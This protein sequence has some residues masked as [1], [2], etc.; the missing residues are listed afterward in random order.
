MLLPP[1]KFEEADANDVIKLSDIQH[2]AHARI[3][4]V[5]NP[6]KGDEVEVYAKDKLIAL[7]PLSPTGETIVQVSRRV[8]LDFAGTGPTPFKYIVYSGS[9]G[10]PSPSVE[11][12][13]VIHH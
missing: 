8:L 7:A 9:S 1:L 11:K 6:Q 10:N 2:Y 12:D 3:A 13:F 4:P 5:P